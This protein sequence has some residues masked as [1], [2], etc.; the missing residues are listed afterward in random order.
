[1]AGTRNDGNNGAVWSIEGGQR[2]DDLLQAMDGQVER[3]LRATAGEGLPHL[4]RRHHRGASGDP[5]QPVGYAPRTMRRSTDHG[6]PALLLP[7]AQA[8]PLRR[9]VLLRAPTRL[10]PRAASDATAARCGRPAWYRILHGNGVQRVG[11]YAVHSLRR[12]VPGTGR[13]IRSAPHARI[14]LCVNRN[15]DYNQHRSNRSIHN[16]RARAENG[17]ILRP[18]LRQRASFQVTVIALI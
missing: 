4:P 7:R 13:P 11:W 17:R 16:R 5:G 1:M 9:P 2:N 15:G 8:R 12:C 10:P 14:L 6:P 3:G 18:P